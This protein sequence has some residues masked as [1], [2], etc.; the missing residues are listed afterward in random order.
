[1]SW[2]MS[3]HVTQMRPSGSHDTLN[4]ERLQC[5]TEFLTEKTLDGESLSRLIKRLATNIRIKSNHIKE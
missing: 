5:E 1:M 3:C 4:V 2:A